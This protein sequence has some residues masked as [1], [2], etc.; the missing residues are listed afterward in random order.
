MTPRVAVLLLAIILPQLSSKT[1]AI[2][3]ESKTV[4]S[5]SVPDRLRAVPASAA[6]RE[7]SGARRRRP[8][9][10]AW[11]RGPDDAGYFS[12]PAQVLVDSEGASCGP[13]PLGDNPDSSVHIGIF[14]PLAKGRP[15]ND[16][17]SFTS[18][19]TLSRR[20]IRIPF[21]TSNC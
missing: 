15:L 13:R 7:S 10:C 12:V 19:R 4:T 2:A 11:A 18:D 3:P 16:L 1:L 14:A 9:F 5:S 6:F 17:A 20:V 8:T 21:L